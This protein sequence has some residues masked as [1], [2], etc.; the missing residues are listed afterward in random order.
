M[1]NVGAYPR[2]EEMGYVTIGGA[3][4]NDESFVHARLGKNLKR[5]SDLFMKRPA[6]RN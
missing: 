4:R 2:M 3:N 6:T 5:D 1:P